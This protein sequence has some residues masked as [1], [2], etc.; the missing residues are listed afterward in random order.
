MRKITLIAR[1]QIIFFTSLLLAIVELSGDERGFRESLIDFIENHAQKMQSKTPPGENQESKVP[2]AIRYEK[3]DWVK[4]VVSKQY[5]PSIDSDVEKKLL[6][7][8]TSDDS[9]IVSY[10][11]LK[12]DVRY[13]KSYFTSG[14]YKRFDEDKPVSKI[15]QAGFYPERELKL[16]L[17]GTVGK[18]LKLY[19]DHDSSKADNQYKMKYTAEEDSEAIREINAGEIDIKLSNSKWAVFDNT[20]RK[21][22]GLDMTIKK[23]R[24]RVKAFGSVNK[25]EVV[26]ER[27]R[28]NSAAKTSDLREY[29]Y[30]RGKYYQL[31]P[32]KRYDNLTSKPSGV[33]AYNLITFTS[34]PPD[35]KR[36]APYAVNVDPGSLELYM[37]DQNPHN[38]YNAITLSLDGGKYVKLSAGIHYTVNF[39]SGLISFIVA[40]PENA[41]IFAL[42]TL[43]GGNTVSS[44]PSARTDVFFGK[45]F[46]FIKYGSSIDEDVNKNFVLDP[47]EDKNG[48]GML[49]LDIYEVRSI[50]SIGDRNILDDNFRI[51]FL[52]EQN[53]LTRAEIEKAGRYILNYSDG[54]I[55][56]HLRQPFQALLGNSAPHIYRENQ[57]NAALQYSRYRLRINYFREARSF[58]LS[59]TNILPGSVRVRINGREIPQSLYTVDHTL[60]YLEF[61]DPTNPLIGSETDIEIRYEYLPIGGGMQSV[62]AGIRADYD[63]NRNLDIGTTV[64]FSRNAGGDSIPKI[65]GE[66]EQLLVFEGDAK[67]SISEYQ[68]REFIRSLSDIQTASVPIEI[69]AYAEC[70]R[71][72]KNINTFGKA[73]IDDMEGGDEVIAISLSERDWI[74]SSPPSS[75]PSDGFPALGQAHRGLLRYLYYRSLE[76]AD[77]LRTLSFT[78]YAIEYSIK[79]GP[80]NVATGHLASN[81]VE[82]SHQRSLVLDFDFSSGKNFVSVV[83]R[84]LSNQPVDFSSLQYVEIWFRPSGG[85]GTVA[86]YIDIGQINEDS[87]SDNMLDTE[88]INNNGFLDYDPAA[89]IFEDEGYLFNPAAGISTR[90]G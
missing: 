5:A 59:H 38:N 44:D 49:N 69:N 4:Y 90:V 39:S 40:I 78:P 15:I 14:K 19:I 42:Y 70:A 27:F 63:V 23:G 21:G 7:I 89:G 11:S 20:A 25:G 26:V 84:R 10:G 80:Y 28:G 48:D 9:N 16:H 6:H 51:D 56:F 71:S 17:E 85:L 73:L 81:I 22:L 64:I 33:A 72:Y 13:G 53:Q 79:P 1:V 68:I 8:E 2:Y 87:D 86:L 24:L 43:N 29:Q 55:A 35:P 74:L 77:T 45:I 60:G 54:T 57:G 34:S 75:L 41:R 36:Y 37:D 47:G 83:T 67:L 88:D 46:V 30:V 65:G 58:Q 61:V 12:M 82:E 3:G 18:R 52:H 76:S 50:Y 32:F 31:E 66:P 62:F